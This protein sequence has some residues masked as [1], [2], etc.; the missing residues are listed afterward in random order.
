MCFIW[1]WVLP[2]RLMA[3]RMA[4][5]PSAAGDVA[6]IALPVNAPRMLLTLHYRPAVA[7][8]IVVNALLLA[9]C[10][11]GGVPGRFMMHTLQMLNAVQAFHL[12]R[13]H[14]RQWLACINTGC[15]ALSI[16]LSLTVSLSFWQAAVSGELDWVLPHA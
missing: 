1:A 16:T 15:L 6:N 11:A 4:V 14:V 7:V 10:C 12:A 5:Q 13:P 3:A 9:V 8:W 2:A